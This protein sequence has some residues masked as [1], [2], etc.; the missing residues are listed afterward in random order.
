MVALVVM[1]RL[2]YVLRCTWKIKNK[3]AY[4]HKMFKWPRGQQT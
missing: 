3:Y 1:L 2:T 4:E